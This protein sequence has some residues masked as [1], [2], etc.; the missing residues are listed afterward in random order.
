MK[1]HLIA[2]LAMLVLGS[3]GVVFGQELD[4]A[5]HEVTVTIPEVAMLR[6]TNGNSN[7]AV[8]ANLAIE[9]DLTDQFTATN[10]DGFLDLEGAY[11]VTNE[12][13]WDDLKVFVNRSASWSVT[14]ELESIDVTDDPT[15]AW[16]KIAV[17]PDAAGLANAFTLNDTDVVT[18]SSER[19]W[20]SLGF[21]PQDFTLTLTGNEIAGEY[22]AVVVYTLSAP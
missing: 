1:K 8:T 5:Q 14:L 22:S 3:S 4:T 20:N 12:P 17:A 16:S 9:F 15:W 7:D 6:F 13:G 10:P 21:G 11:P 2:T 18:T 19:G